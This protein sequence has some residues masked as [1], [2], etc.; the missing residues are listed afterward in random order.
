MRGGAL[1]TQI[2]R[3]FC[4]R[5]SDLL[6]SI[7]S[8]ACFL[9]LGNRVRPYLESLQRIIKSAGAPAPP[10]RVSSLPVRKI[11]LRDGSTAEGSCAGYRLGAPRAQHS[12]AS[13]VP[14]GA[15]KA[16]GDRR[17]RLRFETES[18]VVR[19]HA[20]RGIRQGEGRCRPAAHVGPRDLPGLRAGGMAAAG[21]TRHDPL[22]RRMTATPHDRG[23]VDR[24]RGV[25]FMSRGMLAPIT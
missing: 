7:R 10:K 11:V 15:R 16:G 17:R 4:K 2:C 9:D 25:A 6:I 12:W 20:R 8:T 14:S 3:C 24:R 22:F 21:G 23:T 1:P 19:S 13:R 5:S 18:V